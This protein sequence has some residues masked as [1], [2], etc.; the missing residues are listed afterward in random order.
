MLS[1]GIGLKPQHYDAALAAS[2]DGLWFEVH[3]ENYFVAGGPRIACLDAVRA[4]HPISLHGASLSLAAARPP[5]SVHL[6]RL[7]ALTRRVEP[8]LVSEH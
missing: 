4:R 2:V 6:A 1:A 7:A 5:D 8:A 3:P